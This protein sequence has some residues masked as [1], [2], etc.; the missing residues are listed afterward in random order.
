[1][2]HDHLR[3]RPHEHRN[4]CN[5]LLRAFAEMYAD[6]GPARRAFAAALEARGRVAALLTLRTTPE[7]FGALRPGVDPRVRD[8]A[9]EAADSFALCRERCTRPLVRDGVRLLR[10]VHAARNHDERLTEARRRASKLKYEVEEGARLRERAETHHAEMMALARI[11]YAKPERAVEA[12]LRLHRERGRMAVFQT[13]GNDWKPA[14]R[15]RRTVRKD[16]L[17]WLLG[18]TDTMEAESAFLD[19]RLRTADYPE[20]AEKAPSA[21][22][23]AATRA[24]REVADAE[25]A[26]IE[27]ERAPVP[28]PARTLRM[29]AQVF[30]DAMRLLERR[31]SD[32]V[33]HLTRQLAPMLPDDAHP[34]IAEV[35]Q[36]AARYDD[37]TTR[38]GGKHDRE[39]GTRRY[40]R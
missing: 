22:S 25:L 11:V 10:C 1:V 29:A 6:P 39:R 15:L 9:D 14:G 27:A 28:D 12:V 32:A 18:F 5:A 37:D 23:L 33:P 19:F 40:G 4:V 13:V 31:P 24:A 16:W 21:A 8:F 34:L 38:T 17:G 26:A 20:A 30:H 36:M 2:Y 3:P 35:L 7:D